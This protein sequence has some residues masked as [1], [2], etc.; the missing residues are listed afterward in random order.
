MAS[1]HCS[2]EQLGYRSGSHTSQRREYK[3]EVCAMRQGMSSELFGD[4]WLLAAAVCPGLLVIWGAIVTLHEDWVKRHRLLV[5]FVF[6]LLGFAGTVLT[7]Q[8]NRA[9][10]NLVTGG[11]SFCWIRF[12]N[13]LHSEVTAIIVNHEGD[14]G[15]HSLNLQILDSQKVQQLVAAHQSGNVFDSARKTFGPFDLA[16]DTKN[17]LL[18]Y[19]GETKRDH[20]DFTIN[21]GA[22]N[23]YWQEEVKLTWK[24][25]SGPGGSGGYWMQ[26][27]RVTE[28]KNDNDG[29]L[30]ERITRF[31]CIDSDFPPNE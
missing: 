25:G 13:T 3:A 20:Q 19:Y 29:A 30:V 17:R 4:L 28:E 7:I 24:P 31:T 21:F 8:Q 11:N 14:F 26:A 1:R 27:I 5:L 18:G 10:T 2:R 12:G 15:L 6:L 23:G 9:S 16:A 22:F